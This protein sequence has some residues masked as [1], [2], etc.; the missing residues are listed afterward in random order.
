MRSYRHLMPLP[1]LA[2]AALGLSACAGMADAKMGYYSEATASPMV[3]AEGAYGGAGYGGDSYD[4]AEY[5]GLDE[6]SFNV[7]SRSMVEAKPDPARPDEPPTPDKTAPQEVEVPA[8][9][10][11]IYDANLGLRVF[12]MDEVLDK[13]RAL[14]EKHG[15][16]LQQSTSTSLVMRVPAENFEALVKELEALGEVSYRNVVGTD[17]TE[18]F[19][20]L[21]IRLQNAMTLRERYVK[22][23]TEAKSVEAALAI[24]KEMARLTEDIE[25]MKGRLRFLRDRSAFSTV[26]LNLEQ[27]QPTTSRG[28]VALPFG[29]L[30][31]YHLESILD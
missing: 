26:T 12:R 3:Q 8:K 20:D 24:E 22:L 14:N 1:L 9:R 19:F 23:L 5:D 25:R 4:D 15:G 28:R 10:L 18:E 17:V 29:W 27:K 21:Q 31:G 16:W 6:D 30:Q 2:L 7:D 13:A 11:I